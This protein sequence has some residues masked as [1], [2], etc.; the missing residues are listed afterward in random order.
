M[1]VKRLGMCSGSEMTNM[2]TIINANSNVAA[3]VNKLKEWIPV[4]PS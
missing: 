3:N 4:S 1:F 2:L